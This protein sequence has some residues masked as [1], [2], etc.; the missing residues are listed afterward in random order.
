MKNP[1]TKIIL[2]LITVISR[3]FYL[4]G[5]PLL[6]PPGSIFSGIPGLPKPFC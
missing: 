3:E 2:L 4:F 6:D 1:N 5:K